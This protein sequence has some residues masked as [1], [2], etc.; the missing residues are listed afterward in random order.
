METW[1]EILGKNKKSLFSHG[2]TLCIYC[3]VPTFLDDMLINILC[4]QRTKYKR[5]WY[6]HEK[7][8]KSRSKLFQIELNKSLY[9][10]EEKY[11]RLIFQYDSLTDYKR[12][13][14]G[15]LNKPNAICLRNHVHLVIRRH[16][17]KIMALW[18]LKL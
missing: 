6:N 3:G 13:I 12:H 5:Q 14:K 9:T 15:F 17:F 1:Q 10:R 7:E 4:L 16:R 18:I 2:E 8:V 11:E